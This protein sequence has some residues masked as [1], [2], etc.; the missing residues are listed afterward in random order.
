[1]MIIITNIVENKNHFKLKKKYVHEAFRINW[2]PY[3]VKALSLFSLLSVIKYVDIPI[4][5]Y[6]IVHAI[7]KT[8][9]GGVND[10]FIMP[11]NPSLTFPIR[12]PKNP[13]MF[14]TSMLIISFFHFII[15]FTHYNYMRFFKK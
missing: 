4:R 14:G 5:I 2:I 7:G 15:T 13:K 1:M 11:V 9:A 6:N 8:M 12:L 3:I 10:G